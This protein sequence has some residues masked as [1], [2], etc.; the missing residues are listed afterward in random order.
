MIAKAARLCSLLLGAAE[1]PLSSI[2]HSPFEFN[3]CLDDRLGLISLENLESILSSPSDLSSR[4]RDRL[5]LHAVEPPLFDVQVLPKLTLQLNT[6][7]ALWNLVEFE[8]STQISEFNKANT[9]ASSEYFDHNRPP[10]EPPNWEYFQRSR[11]FVACKNSIKLI[12]GRVFGAD[13]ESQI[14]RVKLQER[15]LR[16][17]RQQRSVVASEQLL[18]MGVVRF[19]TPRGCVVILLCFAF[20]LFSIYYCSV[21]S[22]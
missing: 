1:Q 18:P 15:R 22:L 3:S 12:A 17:R 4:F 10:N 16:R 2:V 14:I 13:Q 11:R 8:S 19:S 20:P 7:P 9:P 21:S 5:S 6:L